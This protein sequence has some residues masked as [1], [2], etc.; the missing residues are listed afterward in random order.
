MTDEDHVP[1]CPV[2]TD[3]TPPEQWDGAWPA[4]RW[5]PELEEVSK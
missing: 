2:C 1:G 3:T 5:S 4:Y